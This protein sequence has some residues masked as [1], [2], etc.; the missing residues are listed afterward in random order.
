MSEGFKDVDECEYSCMSEP[1]CPYCG[2]KQGDGVY[3]EAVEVNIEEIKGIFARLKQIESV[4]LKEIEWY[5]K[6]KKLEISD[7][8]IDEFR[9]CGMCNRDFILTGEYKRGER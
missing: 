6:G 3:C 4:H 9:F 5:E 7:A 8:I 1:V 2:F